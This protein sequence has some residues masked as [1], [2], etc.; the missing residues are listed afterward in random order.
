[1]NYEKNSVE[2]S[3]RRA[4]LRSP[5][6]PWSNSASPLWTQSSIAFRPSALKE[7][8]GQLQPPSVRAV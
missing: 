8:S 2:C 6:D 5:S 4:H 7:T 3:R 1:M